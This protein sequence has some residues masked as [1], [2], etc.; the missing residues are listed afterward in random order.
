MACQKPSLVLE[1]VWKGGLYGYL[2][3]TYWYIAGRL[4]ASPS[5]PVLRNCHLTVGVSQASHVG[6]AGPPEKQFADVP[7]RRSMARLPLWAG[8][9]R[10]PKEKS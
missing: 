4:F 10:K 2:R 7:K 9:Q 5:E 1:K 3:D 8:R 6:S